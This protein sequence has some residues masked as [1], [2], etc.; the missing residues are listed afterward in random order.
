AGAAS[1]SITYLAPAGWAYDPPGGEGAAQMVAQ[2]VT[3][4]AGK[5]DRVALARR[6]DELGATVTA[7]SHPES[8][9]ITAWGPTDAFR[10]LMAI[11]ADV[12]IRPR[13]DPKDIDRVRRQMYEHQL[14]E[15]TQPGSRAERALFEAVFP[16]GH[17]YRLSGIG[18]RRSIGRL[19]RG[20]LHR[21]HRDH[22]T[23]EGAMV[24]VTAADSPSAV[25]KEAIS[26]FR[27]FGRTKAPPLPEVP[28]V[29]VVRSRRLEVEM[30]TRAQVEVRVGGVSVPRASSEYAGVYLANEILGGRT[31][32][33]RLFQRVRE[34]QG[35]A[36][37]ASS[38]VDC[39]R[40]GGYWMAE[41]GTGPERAARTV[42]LVE[43]EVRRMGE[44]LVL[45]GELN[46]IRDSAIGELPLRLED[47]S[48]A[49]ELALDV[50]YHGLAPDHYRTWSGKLRALGPA[51][52]RT[53]AE[54]ALDGTHAITVLAGPVR[55]TPRS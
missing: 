31:L 46:E 32:L 12:A 11:L 4:A 33:N 17:P 50:A 44:E 35:L 25:R 21:F 15:A 34:R 40:Y 10:E 6:L 29:P 45:A 49:H 30:P 20:E 14:R 39:M 8:S 43:K 28:P 18:S 48:G 24:V 2:L 36:Y 53:A 16:P 26:A 42:A 51:E 7:K 9:E 27:G 47:T 19:G 1:V 52:V 13:F 37:H 23:E 55:P 22:F 38:E 3:S 41:A 54:V 5:R